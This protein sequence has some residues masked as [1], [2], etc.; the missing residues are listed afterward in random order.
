M[1]NSIIVELCVPILTLI[2]TWALTRVSAMLDAKKNA[3]NSE[4]EN[5]TFAEYVTLALDAV[6]TVVDYLNTTT[7]ND[8]KKAAADGKLTEEE[9]TAVFNKAKSEILL[10]LSEPV[11]TA[12]SK[13]Y[14]DLDRMLDI[15]ITNAVQN[16]KTTG[17]T[18]IT[19]EKAVRLAH[20]A[21]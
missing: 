20:A 15:W 13:V 12:L 1:E 9:A 5:K 10:L 6:S 4:V 3:I 19:S 14:G 7:V 21:Q 18:G 17:L 8:M 2:V 11:T 16:A